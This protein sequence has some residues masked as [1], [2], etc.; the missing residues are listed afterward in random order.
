MGHNQEAYDK[1]DTMETGATTDQTASEIIAD[2]EAQDAGQRL[3]HLKLDDSDANTH[4]SQIH[5]IESH[6]GTTGTG[7]ELTELTN[8]SDT[9]LHIHDNRYF[10]EVEITAMLNDGT[11]KHDALGNLT[12]DTHPQ[13]LK[14]DGSRDLTGAWDTKGQA[15]ANVN[16]T[17]GVINNITD[18]NVVDGGTGASTAPDARTNLG[19]VIGTDVAPQSHTLVTNPDH[20]G[21]LLTHVGTD[22]PTTPSP[23]VAGRQWLDT[24]EDLPDKSTFTLRSI[25][26]TQTLLVTDM[27]ILASGTITL[28]LPVAATTNAGKTIYIKN[29]ST[30]VITVDGNGSETIDSDADIDLIQHET[31]RVVNDQ[32]EWWII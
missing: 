22:A 27:T 7:A 28:T 16:I 17:S 3:S 15:M 2:L 23:Q 25:S 19:L 26:T 32:T 8:G 18:L 1:L 29:I 30:G 13:Y 12:L 24:N 9:S 31:I 4:H 11:V 10:T 20:D 6:S 21:R 14:T 5:T